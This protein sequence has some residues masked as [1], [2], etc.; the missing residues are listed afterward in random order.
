MQWG[1]N[2]DR[3]WMVID[4][5]GRGDGDLRVMDLTAVD[6]MMATGGQQWTD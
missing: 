3:R 4:G 1:L 2:S 5:N 6:G